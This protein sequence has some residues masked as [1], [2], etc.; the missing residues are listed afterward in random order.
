MKPNLSNIYE[1]TLPKILRDN[2]HAKGVNYI[3][4]DLGIK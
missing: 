4:E 2:L 1:F 3:Q